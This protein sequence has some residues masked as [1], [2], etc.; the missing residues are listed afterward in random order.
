MLDENLPSKLR[1]HLVV[2]LIMLTLTAFYIN[3]STDD[4][5][6]NATIY[7]A[8][9]GAEAEPAYSIRH[10]DPSLP[11]S[12][13]RYAAA[14]FDSYN[15][16]ILFGEVLLIPQWTQPNPT[17]EEIRLNGGVP[18]PPQPIL[19]TEFT[20]QLYN[21]DQQVVVKQRPKTW[22]SAPYWEF[23]MPQ[24]TFRRPS[25][26]A[27]DRTQ[28]DP[29]A[30]DTTPK[31]NFKWKK[32]GTLSKDLVC[33]LSGKS[34]NPDG[35]KRK[36]REPDITIAIFKH[37]REITIYEPNMNRV[38]MEDPKGLEI[39]LLLSAAVI[40]DVYYAPIRETFNIIEA[41]RRSSN[42]LIPSSKTSSAATAAL[43]PSP[44]PR[45]QSGSPRLYSTAL[46]SQA[47]PSSNPIPRPPPQN[48]ISNPRPPPTDPRSQWEL[49]AETARLRKQVEAEERERK[50]AEHKEL[51]RLK[52]MLEDEER[53]AH[54]KQA[55]IDRETER[56]RREYADEPNRL[57]SRT[58]RP[59]LPQ[60]LD[61]ASG[62]SSGGF[63][64][65]G[66]SSLRPD[67]GRRLR[68]KMSIFGLRSNNGADAQ[69][70][71][72]KRSAVF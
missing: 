44:P 48:P 21:P 31:I 37:L 43:Y 18:P 29:T 60:R 35:S 24:Q 54:R 22:N 40:R 32:E 36:N 69:K 3:P 67:D 51:K 23:E 7:L 53:E 52:K 14:L 15:P 19:P 59:P 46:Q 66:A 61:V 47:S 12:K 58:S 28:N 38:D 64:G 17:Q 20:V 65:G 16:E 41:P 1:S 71:F 6:H 4:T 50:R 56:L 63:Y 68:G 42:G 8:H 55:E 2:G 30:A 9:R 62:S 25:A 72:K 45:R 10:P 49:D 34:T 27:L 39:V 26:S 11:A 33:S 5:K 70:L 13:N 57:N